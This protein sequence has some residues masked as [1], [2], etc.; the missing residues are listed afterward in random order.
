[1]RLQD[2][3]AIGALLTAA[4]A[5]SA[6]CG[7]STPSGGSRAA[8]VLEELIVTAQ[9]RAEKAQDVPIAMSVLDAAAIENK[10][11][12]SIGDLQRFV[13]SFSFEGPGEKGFG[14]PRIRGVQGGDKAPGY[15]QPVAVFIDG[16]YFGRPADFGDIQYDLERIEVLRGPQGTLFGKN[17]TAGLINITTSEPTGES[18]AMLSG[19]LGNYDKVQT[20]AS[21]TGPLVEGRLLGKLSFSSDKSSGVTRNLVTGVKLDDRDSLN[22]RGKLVFTPSDNWRLSLTAFKSRVD[23]LPEAHWM[24]GAP[25]VAG[26]LFSSDP[27]TAYASIDGHYKRDVWGAYTNAEYVGGS[28]SF[29]SITSYKD[30]FEDTLHSTSGTNTR[31]LSDINERTDSKQFTQ[32][33]QFLSPSDA[34]LTWIGGAYYQHLHETYD[35]TLIVDFPAGTTAAFLTRLLGYP[36]TPAANRIFQDIVTNSYAVFGQTTYA[37]TPQL[38]VTLGA[39][40]TWDEKGGTI[41]TSGQ[42]N[43]VVL[44]SQP[45]SI[46]VSASWRAFTP[47]VV[48]EYKPGGNVLLYASAARG[49][50]G[51]GY[52]FLNPEPVFSQI[53]YK[54]EYV[55]NYELGMKSEFLNHRIQ[56]NPT[57]YY[58]DYKDRQSTGLINGFLQPITSDAVIKGLELDAQAAASEELHLTF[59]YAYT[60]LEQK[61]S[62]TASAAP[63]PSRHVATLGFDYDVGRPIAGGAVRFGADAMYRSKQIF[64][65]AP[66]ANIDSYTTI[67]A[68][69]SYTRGDI[70]LSLWGTNLT[71]KRARGQ[72]ALD[73]SVFFQPLGSTGKNYRVTFSRP[74]TYGLTLTWR[75][76]VNP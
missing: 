57:I 44:T 1:M 48:V 46:P 67:D 35:T 11:I 73:Q 22:I 13:P 6:A 56:F 5:A 47:K 9:K 12:T 42:R 63:E 14:L 74:R 15:D 17:V 30:S 45:F 4:F 34:A 41:A 8:P 39:R 10:R 3:A 51:G 70:Q 61:G 59:A 38:D 43:F 25:T 27:A 29:R 54:P 64:P 75:L 16:V 68:R 66:L 24:I 19:T 72:Y 58:M 71:D 36:P 52:R 21:V 62:T 28:F 20:Y 60:D 76:G 55:T 23:E 7:Q 65:A 50:K 53:P 40:Y 32:E 33:A 31:F 49:Y 37:V 26:V 18:K 2:Q 69:A